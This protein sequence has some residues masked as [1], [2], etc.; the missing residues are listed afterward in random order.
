MDRGRLEAFSDGV[1]AVAIT[2]LAL[3]LGVTGPG[4]PPLVRQ[5][6]EH[7]PV[8]AAYVVSFFTIGIIWVNHHALFTAMDRIDRTQLF[9]NLLLLLFVVAIPFAT[10]T[11]AEYLRH[12][13]RSASVAGLLY[14]GVMEG[15]SL[16]FVAIFVHA[17][18]ANLLTAPPPPEARRG[19]VL[20]FSLGAAAY[21]VVMGV[22]LV[23]PV[24]T[25]VLAGAVAAYY[26]FQRTP[27]PGTPDRG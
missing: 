20:R 17:L 24:W 13:D 15:L 3:D 16:S 2:L 7:W 11:L 27:D 22:A 26:V 18:R 8:F 19:A 1:F 21:L 23:S 4:G 14:G 9:W 5:L 6:A 25:L 10:S 12:A